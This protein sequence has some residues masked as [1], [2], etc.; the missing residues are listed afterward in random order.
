MA[1]S[2]LYL[3]ALLRNP[4]AQGKQSETHRLASDF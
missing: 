4:G 3:F 2:L 1:K